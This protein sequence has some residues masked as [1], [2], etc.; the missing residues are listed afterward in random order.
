MTYDLGAV[1]VRLD[2][3]LAVATALGLVDG[4]RSVKRLARGILVR[5]PAHAERTPSCSIGATGNGVVWHCFA[6]GAAGG[7]LE[8]VATVARIDLRTDFR[9]VVEIAAAMTGI[10]EDEPAPT[11]APPPRPPE[12][13]RL[14]DETFDAIAQVI[15]RRC[16]IDAAP[17]VAAYLDARGLYE[18]AAGELAALPA[19]LDAQARL[20]DAI[21]ADV[22][23]DA[24]QRSGLANAR[25]TFVFP[26]HRLVAF[27]RGPTGEVQT[28]QRRVLRGA[29]E[30]RYVFATRRSPLY[31][32]GIERAAALGPAGEVAFC[33]GFLDALALRHLSA[34]A[35]Y[36][37]L[38]LGLPGVGGWKQPWAQVAAARVAVVATDPDEAGEACADTLARDLYGA[39][40]LDVK[41]ATPDGAHDWA[42]VLEREQGVAA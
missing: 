10:R 22:G 20:V 23:E 41:R 8:L 32:Y 16:P 38:V 19:D 42:E 18:A 28:L 4:P 34:R 21:A 30:P 12:P 5:C 17:D 39:G 13:E 27:W 35:G 29:G 6:C 40:A 33:E 31:P 3:P 36:D 15:A 7:V 1:R 9:R 37:R 26:A 24:W 2:D 25:G 14:D 11:F